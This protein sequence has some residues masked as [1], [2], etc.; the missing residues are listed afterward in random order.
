M[1][2]IVVHLQNG[3]G[4]YIFKNENYEF[5]K[6]TNIRQNCKSIKMGCL[7]LNRFNKLLNWYTNLIIMGQK[8]KTQEEI[9]LT[10]LEVNKKK[11]QA[12]ALELEKLIIK[13][14]TKS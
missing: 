2:F 7:V 14:K 5:T 3:Q 11:L 9:L 4:I 10:Q 6:I 8:I 12:K 13:L 1:C